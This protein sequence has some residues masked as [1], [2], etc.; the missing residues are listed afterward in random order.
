MINAYIQTFYSYQQYNYQGTVSDIINKRT[1]NNKINLT[2]VWVSVDWRDTDCVLECD[3]EVVPSCSALGSRDN[4]RKLSTLPAGVECSWFRP[5]THPPSLVGLP[6]Y[7]L[8]TVFVQCA[9]AYTLSNRSPDY[10]EASGS[11]P[12]S[13]DQ[14]PLPHDVWRT[15]GRLKLSRD[16]QRSVE[17]FH[18]RD[19]LVVRLTM[20]C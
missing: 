3:Q 7:H 15:R 5:V 9:A 11:C 8:Q 13:S 14:V 6:V 16:L 17:Q 20:C 12:R 4:N 19:L 18:G 10:F 2:H 1:L